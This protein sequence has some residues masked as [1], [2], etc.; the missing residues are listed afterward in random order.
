MPDLSTPQ[1]R[2]KHLLQQV[3]EPGHCRGC[4]TPVYWVTHRNGVK[5]PYTLEGLNHFADCPVRDQFI[6]AEAH[7]VVV[8]RPPD[9]PDSTEQPAMQPPPVSSQTTTLCAG[10]ILP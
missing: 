2:L 3:G 7:A 6:G 1:A 5:A 9:G 4:S 8:P 10:R